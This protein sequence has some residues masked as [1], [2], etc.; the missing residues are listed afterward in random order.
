MFFKKYKTLLIMLSIILVSLLAACSSETSGVDPDA[1]FDADKFEDELTIHFFHMEDDKKTG[2][3]IFLK[4]PEGQTIL[5]DAGIPDSG[6]TVDDYLDKLEV[7]SIDLVM[8]SHPHID[9]IGGLH[10]IFKTKDIGKVL[11]TNVPHDTNTYRTYKEIMESE[12]IPYEYV[13]AGDVIE[14][15]DDLVMEILNPPAGTSED[16]L[17]EGYSQMG[18][19]HINNVST[20]IKLTHG[21]N[22]FMF[23]GDI[24][25]AREVELVSDYGDEL[26]S[27]V[28]V[29]PH[30]GDDTSSTMGF[31]EAV[32]PSIAVIPSNL[33][34]S[35]MVND[36]YVDHGSDLYH[37]ALDG[38]IL[39]V[40]DGKDINVITEKERAN[41]KD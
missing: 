5:I 21:E 22:T 9:H 6:P 32:D 12:D 20:V 16:T 37:N 10:T 14:L 27:D 36:K 25:T 17:P 2:E 39:L 24:Y 1:I 28:L 34:F 29:A 3:S 35:I 15:E 4:T 13:E 31:I 8:P 40:S 18:A 33:L 7:D 30:H 38:N 26:K 41:K 23:T 19:G 11:E